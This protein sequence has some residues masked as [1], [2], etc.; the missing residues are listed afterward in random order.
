MKTEQPALFRQS[1]GTL[2]HLRRFLAVTLALVLL[3]T[4]P[5]A[6]AQEKTGEPD[7]ETDRG[8]PQL[9]KTI[10]AQVHDEKM[11]GDLLKG[12][13]DH[14]CDAL[15]YML[16]S[17]PPLTEVPTEGPTGHA[18]RVTARTAEILK[19]AAER[20][21]AIQGPYAREIDGVDLGFDFEPEV[22][23]MWS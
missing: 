13:T 5:G 20:H 19:E 10:P 18:G 11:S 1:I 6:H 21:N 12:S 23:S 15:R 9:I 2:S 14:W 8:C 3:S 4:G 22:S 16:M 7:P 17:R